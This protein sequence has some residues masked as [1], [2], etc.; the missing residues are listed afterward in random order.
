MDHPYLLTNLLHIAL[1]QRG[2]DEDGFSPP[3]HNRSTTI[4]VNYTD[5]NLQTS[6]AAFPTSEQPVF[7]ITFKDMLLSPQSSLMANVYSLIQKFTNDMQHMEE[8]VQYMENKMDECTKTVNNLVHAYVE[9]RDDNLQIKEKL[10]DLKDH[11]RRNNIKLGVIPE[12]ILPS[13]LHK[14]TRD[15]ISTMLSDLTPIE[16]TI[17]RI[18]K[19]S[20][21]EDTVPRDVLMRIHF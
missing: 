21:L 14:Y 16:L 17:D 7:D 15:L 8:R 9:Q 1:L 3:G 18:P 12:A 4:Q 2:Q 19:P 13:D 20:H 11:T 5:I 6:I 10:A